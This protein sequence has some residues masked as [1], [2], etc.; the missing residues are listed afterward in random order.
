[1]GQDKKEQDKKACVSLFKRPWSMRLSDTMPS[2]LLLP[3]PSIGL[4]ILEEGSLPYPS[5]RN[6]NLTPRQVSHHAN[7]PR[8]VHDFIAL[9]C[10]HNHASSS[11]SGGCGVPSWLFSHS[12]CHTI[13]LT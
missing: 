8:P 7:A 12:I 2:S 13:P 4:S 9:E 11:V 10:R 5:S 6:Q 1:M 3:S